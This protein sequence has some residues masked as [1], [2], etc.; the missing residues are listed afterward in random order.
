MESLFNIGERVVCVDSS[1]HC[2]IDNSVPP[3]LIE[4]KTYPVK[5]N[6]VCSCGIISI[7]VGLKSNIE[8]SV[9]NCGRYTVT[10]QWFVNQ[11]RF[12]PIDKD[13]L[14]EEEIRDALLNY[15]KVKM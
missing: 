2:T 13:I 10:K 3:P 8:I 9:C 6:Q 4:G 14:M 7:D 12:I 11:N 5:A 15:L 1:N